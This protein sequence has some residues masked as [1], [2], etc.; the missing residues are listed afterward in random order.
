MRTIALF[1]ACMLSC[2]AAAEPRRVAWSQT[3]EAFL[4]KRVLIQLTCGARI[5]GS[6]I[7]ITANTFTMHVEKT[8]ARNTIGKGIQT[9]PRSSI[10]V[11]RTRN[12]RVRGRVAGALAGFY[13]VAAISYA[14]TGSREALQSGWGPAAFAGGVAGYFAGRAADRATHE[15]VLLP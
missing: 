8:S 15:V 6:W 12:Q 3:P 13:G 4:G 2:E 11:I 5:E 14:A 1:M 10:L 7:S 9:L